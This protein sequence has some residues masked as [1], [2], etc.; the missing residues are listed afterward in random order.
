M[1]RIARWLYNNATNLCTGPQNGSTGGLH[2]R[3][4]VRKQMTGSF[5][6]SHYGE[7][8]NGIR[9]ASQKIAALGLPNCCPTIDNEDLASRDGRLIGCQIDSHIGHVNRQ[10]ETKQVRGSK[11]LD[12]L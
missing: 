4:H 12:V 2:A 9:R 10:T 6:W 11:L 8:A 7:A 3:E 1:S 5:F